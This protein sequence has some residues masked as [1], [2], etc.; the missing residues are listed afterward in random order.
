MQ[1]KRQVCKYSVILRF[2]AEELE[3]LKCEEGGGEGLRGFGSQG[4]KS[5]G[6]VKSFYDLTILLHCFFSL[7]FQSRREQS[8]FN[9]KVFRN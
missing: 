3:S 7:K 9:S 8:I 6:S 5:L 1:D 2:V 4:E